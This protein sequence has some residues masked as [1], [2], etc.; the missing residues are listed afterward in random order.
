MLEELDVATLHSLFSVSAK[1]A[2]APRAKDKY[3]A[4]IASLLAIGYFLDKSSL[5]LEKFCKVPLTNDERF[6]ED[7]KKVVQSKEL[8]K[9]LHLEQLKITLSP[10][11]H[12]ILTE[13]KKCLL[14]KGEPGSGKTVLL[15]AKAYVAGQDHTISHIYYYAPKVKTALREEVDQFV[16]FPKYREFFHERFK[17]LSDHELFDLENKSFKELQNT[18][19]LIDEIYFEDFN[20]SKQPESNHSFSC[21]FFKLSQKVFPFLRNCWMSNIV[22]SSV[23]DNTKTLSRLFL[24]ELFSIEALNVQFRSSSHIGFLSTNNIHDSKDVNWFSVRMPGTFIASQ[25]KVTFHEYSSIDAIN[26]QEL[27]PDLKQDRWAI[28]FCNPSDKSKWLTRTKSSKKFRKIFITSSAAG[29]HDCEFSGGQAVSVVVIIDHVSSQN[30]E[31][32]HPVYNLAMNRAQCNLNVYVNK[33]YPGT[34]SVI[35]NWTGE[36]QGPDKF[37]MFAR[38]QL[39]IDYSDA[40]LTPE[41][42]D[43]LYGIAITYSD[44]TVLNELRKYFPN[45]KPSIEAARNLRGPK[46]EKFLK[47]LSDGSHEKEWKMIWMQDFNKHSSSRRSVQCLT[48]MVFPEVMGMLNFYCVLNC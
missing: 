9:S 10:Q 42:V 33:K 2:S 8:L 3:L 20:E 44:I 37:L 39:P 41:T 48:D 18:V 34:M 23:S 27:Q 14:T 35:K 31:K 36:K 17:Y 47:K 43:K 6:Q 28:V 15:L 30:S 29:Y 16:N 32:L 25:T 46:D 11:Q 12:R 4:E 38:Q 45:T 5:T 21:K 24:H 40:Q 1:L 22:A 13:N 19:L 7:H 26:L